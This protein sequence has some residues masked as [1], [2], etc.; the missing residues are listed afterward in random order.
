MPKSSSAQWNKRAVVI[1][2]AQT[3]FCSMARKALSWILVE[4]V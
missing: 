3:E 4:Y 1:P 2:R